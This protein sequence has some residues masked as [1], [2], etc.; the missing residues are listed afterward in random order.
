MAFG[1]PQ[2]H[3]IATIIHIFAAVFWLGWMVFIFFVLCPVTSRLDKV[4]VMTFMV[5]VRSRVRKIVFWLIP[6]IILTGLYNMGYRGLLDWH[7]LTTTPTGHRMLWKLGAAL[8]LFGIYYFA[9]AILGKGFVH[10]KNEDKSQPAKPSLKAKKVE[11][12]L[13]LIAFTAG[14]VAA[15]LGITIGG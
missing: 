5:P 15:Y 13:H 12:V 6:I 11:V 8:V 7:V 2:L 9:P 1:S 4:D 3:F 14:C 10:K